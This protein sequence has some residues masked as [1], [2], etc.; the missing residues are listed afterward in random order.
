MLGPAVSLLLSASS[1][2]GVETVLSEATDGAG[3]RSCPGQ[4]HFI[5]S[6][7]AKLSERYSRMG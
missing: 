3:V 5:P 4:H 1:W 6:L 7:V 2:V